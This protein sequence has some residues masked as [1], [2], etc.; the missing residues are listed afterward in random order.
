MAQPNP[1]GARLLRS[2][3]YVVIFIVAVFAILMVITAAAGRGYVDREVVSSSISNTYYNIWGGEEG[4]ISADEPV[5]K[6]LD[7]EKDTPVKSGLEPAS[8]AEKQSE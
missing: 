3:R 5:S 8:G 2:Q 4:D 6:Q 1:I 7:P